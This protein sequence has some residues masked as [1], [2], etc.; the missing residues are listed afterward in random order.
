MHRNVGQGKRCTICSRL[1]EERAQA[2]TEEAKAAVAIEKKKHIDSVM[3]DRAVN[4]RGN[5]L[6]ETNARNPTPN[7]ASSIIKVV[8]DGMDQAK[9]KTPRCA[10]GPG[11]TCNRLRQSVVLCHTA[12]FCH[13]P[14]SLTAG[15]GRAPPS[16]AASGGRNHTYALESFM[17]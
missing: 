5:V 8:V 2:A 6:A 3:R 4:V 9:F 12:W 7:G 14:I 16:S 15:L 17:R 1:D 11:Q 10:V 13:S